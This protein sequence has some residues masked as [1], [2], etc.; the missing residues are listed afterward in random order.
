MIEEILKYQKL[1]GELLKLEKEYN[2][3]P[4]RQK[5]AQMQ[6]ILKDSQ[7]RIGVIEHNAQK[8]AENFAKAKAYYDDLVIKIESLSKG[9]SQN[10]SYEKIKELQQ[11]KNNFYQMIDKLEKEL[12]KIN[13]QLTMVANEYNTVIKNAKQAKANLEE[14]RTKVLELKSKYEPKIEEL[15]VQLAEQEKMVDKKILE[16]YRAKRESKFPVL[17]RVVNGTCGGCRMTISASTMQTFDKNGFIECEHCGRIII[18]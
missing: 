1:D 6:T 17:V 4:E 18:K 12:T 9:L 5:A 2:S 10:A 3:A 13:A 14:Y 15:K 11:A 8:T 16:K 7:S